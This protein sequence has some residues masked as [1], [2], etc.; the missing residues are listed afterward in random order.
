MEALGGPRNVEL[1]GSLIPRSKGRGTGET[2][3]PLYIIRTADWFV[4][5]F[6]VDILGHL[7]HILL[8]AISNPTVTR[9]KGEEEVIWCSCCQTTLAT[10]YRYFALLIVVC[11]LRCRVEFMSKFYSGEGYT[12]EPFS[13]EAC[14]SL[15]T[16]E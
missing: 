9:R 6:A 12:F 7:W 14:L 15:D 8:D 10:C 1:D 3:C 11:R 4:V 5:L 16:D 2:F 13:F